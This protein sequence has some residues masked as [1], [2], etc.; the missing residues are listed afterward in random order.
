MKKHMLALTIALA[1]VGTACGG[2]DSNGGSDAAPSD[3]KAQ[4]LLAVLEADDEF[5]LTEAEANCTVNRLVNDLD[6]STI[7]MI[8]ADPESELA[9]VVSP[10]ENLVAVNALL[11]CVDIEQMMITSM[12]E[13]GTDRE[14]AECV[15]AG[16]GEDEL[17]TFME[18]AT[19]PEDQI[20][21]A[22]AFEIVG[23]MFEIAVECG[24][25]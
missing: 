1:L 19:L 15:A 13:D 20:D 12:M 14:T 11:D 3:P 8:L 5:P 10:E 17:R 9:D 7:D 4:E 25:E 16:F 24:L 22:A 21:E 18:A 23:K 6:D 2:D